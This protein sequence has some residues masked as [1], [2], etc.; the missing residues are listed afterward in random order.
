MHS[1]LTF[2]LVLDLGADTLASPILN[3]SLLG[4][5]VRIPCYPSQSSPIRNATSSINNAIKLT[6]STG[7][8]SYGPM[9][10][11]STSFSM[12]L[13]SVNEDE[14]MFT[15]HHAASGLA[16]STEGVMNNIDSNTVWRIGSV[17]KFVTVH[18]AIL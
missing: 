14:P 17:W 8:S 5:D 3:C 9:D 16:N 15:Y 4:P 18:S 7:N 6:I 11:S 2:S 12:G 1:L 13:F 10:T